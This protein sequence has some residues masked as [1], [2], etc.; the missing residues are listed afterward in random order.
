MPKLKITQELLDLL[1]REFKGA[2]ILMAPDGHLLR[3]GI[4]DL[5]TETTG[6]S[7]WQPAND[8]AKA[9]F[10]AREACQD[11]LH[12]SRDFAAVPFRRVLKTLSV[13]LVNLLDQLVRLLNLTGPPGTV[14]TAERA[15]WPPGDRQV[16]ADLSRAV[17]RHKG[18]PVRHVRNKMGG[19]LDDAVLGGGRPALSAE[20][21]LTVLQHCAALLLLLLNHRRVYV[22]VRWVATPAPGLHVVE[23]FFDYPAVMRWLADDDGNI[24]AAAISYLAL[25]PRHEFLDTFKGVFDA[26][27]A[28]AA[29]A[30]CGL[31]TLTM[32]PMEG[33]GGASQW[34]EREPPKEMMMARPIDIAVD[35]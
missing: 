15:L 6:S 29:H 30:D 28:L 25:D 19:H 24:A 18:G 27:N 10:L 14:A 26:Y 23:T 35:V 33:Q 5:L 34:D 3:P 11:V 31:P 4:A 2:P 17:R 13:P 21:T 12:A 8:E 1:A 7:S 22:W 9:L 32:N 20:Q 16:F